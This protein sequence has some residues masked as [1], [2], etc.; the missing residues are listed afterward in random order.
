MTKAIRNDSSC[1]LGRWCAR[2][3]QP[4]PWLRGPHGPRWPHWLQRRLHRLPLA[5]AAALVVLAL[6]LRALV[7]Q[8]FMPGRGAFSSA[9]PVVLCTAQ[10][11]L[12]VAAAGQPQELPEHSANVCA[13]AAAG[14]QGELDEPWPVPLLLLLLALGWQCLAWPRYRAPVRTPCLL[15]REARAP[16]L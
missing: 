11:P 16:P 7:P 15:M 10:G 5:W 2:S 13:W 8:G 6:L 12:V 3:G 1:S 14:L 4:S 9:L